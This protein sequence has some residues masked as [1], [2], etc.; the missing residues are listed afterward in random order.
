MKEITSSCPCR[1]RGLATA[2]FFIVVVFVLV[3]FKGGGDGVEDEGER[4][5]M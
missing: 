4:E 3:V 1:S 2:L 5:G